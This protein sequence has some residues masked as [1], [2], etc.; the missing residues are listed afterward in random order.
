MFLRETGSLFGSMLSLLD[1]YGEFISGGL[2]FFYGKVLCFIAVSRL[3][4]LLL[5]RTLGSVKLLF[6]WLRPE[7]N[8]SLRA[9]N[10]FSN[11]LSSIDGVFISDRG[12]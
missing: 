2:E 6:S 4:F 3:E 12:G 5:G 8:V 1:L 7:V 11:D 10:Y 9:A